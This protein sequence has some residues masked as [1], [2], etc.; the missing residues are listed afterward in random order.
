MASKNGKAKSISHL[1]DLIPDSQNARKHGS[2]NVG[3]IEM[4]LGEVGAGR[5]IVID[6]HGA[7]LAGNATVEAAARAGIERVQVV[8]ADGE[9]IIAV[10]RSGLT[11]RQKKRLALLDNAPNAPEANPEYWD[12]AVITDIAKRERELLDG[13]FR[14][15]E[16]NKLVVGIQ[17][18][19]EFKE[20]GEGIETNYCCP[21]CGYRWSGK[22]NQE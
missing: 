1:R 22:P 13:I 16:L 12:D 6:E 2:R 5:S 3:L 4:S 21:K 7:V 18:P 19:E 8:E 9:S 17:A 11:A 14:D 10:R 20:Y 15:D